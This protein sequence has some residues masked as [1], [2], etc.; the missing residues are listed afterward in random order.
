VV[1]LHITEEG[2]DKFFS[3]T[4]VKN[5]SYVRHKCFIQKCLFSKDR[6]LQM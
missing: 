3:L 1:A 5:S 6:G 2:K 4:N